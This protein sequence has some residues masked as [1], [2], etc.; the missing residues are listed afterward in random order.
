MQLNIYQSK[1]IMGSFESF[2]SRLCWW[3]LL[4]KLHHMY[5]MSNQLHWLF[6][7]I[8]LFGLFC[9]LLYCLSVEC[10]SNMSTMSCLMPVLHVSR[11]LDMWCR[12][13][14]WASNWISA[15]YGLWMFLML[16]NAWMLTVSILKLVYLVFYNW[17]CDIPK[18]LWL[19]YGMWRF[20]HKMWPK[21]RM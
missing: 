1:W 10:Q 21:S 18:H 8:I 9:K 4:I 17:L 7:P 16:C 20:L 15:K 3:L 14:P 19:M 5:S 11:M 13:L 2:L 12:I 6:E